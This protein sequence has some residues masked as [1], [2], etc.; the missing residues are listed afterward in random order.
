MKIISIASMRALEAKAVAS[1]TPE[2]RLM[3]RAGVRAAAVLEEFASNRFRRLVFFC[4]GGNNGGDAIVA[5][6]S[7]NRLPHVFLPFKDPSQLQGAA[8]EAFQEFGPRLNMEDPAL[9]DFARGR[10]HGMAT[11]DRL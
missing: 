2:Y 7:L 1:G 6:G 3:R 4:G 8:K 9:F 11:D 10:K 5:A